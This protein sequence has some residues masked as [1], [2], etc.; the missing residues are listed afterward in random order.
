M[1][2]I[3]QEH[4]SIRG[5][6]GQGV[7]KSGEIIDLVGFGEMID[8]AGEQYILSLVYDIT[9]RKKTEEALRES[10]ERFSTF[11]RNSPV[12]T[13]ITRLSDGQFVDANDAFLR[14]CGYT[15]EEVIGQDPVKLGFWPNAEARAKFVEV[16]LEQGGLK[17]FQTQCVRKSGEIRNV[18]LS[19]EVI[20][21]VGEQYILALAFDITERNRIEEALR[22]SEKRFSTFFRNSPVGT[23]ITRLRDGQFVDVNDAFLRLFGYTREEVIGQDALKRGMWANPEERTKFVEVIQ[24]HG[25]IKEFETRFGRKPVRPGM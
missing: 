4:D 9:E 14:L 18:S 7:R 11:F 21:A 22:E 8:I 1:L 19:S 16:M 25:R 6:E 5:I 12:G 3:L 23:A 2:A 15:R 13:S 10:E 17:D 24:E 20:E